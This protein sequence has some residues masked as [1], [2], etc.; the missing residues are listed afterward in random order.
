MIELEMRVERI[1]KEKI[2]D[3][4]TLSSTHRRLT[5]ESLSSDKKLKTSGPIQMK[6]KYSA[7]IHSSLTRIRERDGAP[8]CWSGRR[9]PC[10][11]YRH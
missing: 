8:C 4:V 1:R 5:T 10:Q 6:K 2:E 9:C 11:E 3:I 7:L